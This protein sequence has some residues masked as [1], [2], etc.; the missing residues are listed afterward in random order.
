[1]IPNYL[2]SRFLVLVQVLQLYF[3]VVVSKSF[4]LIFE[5]DLLCDC[6]NS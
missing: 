1:M 2:Y 4:N 3:N 5:A 6:I